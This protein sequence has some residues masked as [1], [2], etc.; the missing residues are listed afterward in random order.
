MMEGMKKWHEM[1][2]VSGWDSVRSTERDQPL[3][4]DLWP[5]WMPQKFSG[6]W[7]TALSTT[8]CLTTGMLSTGNA[9]AYL[10]VERQH[11]QGPRSSAYRYDGHVIGKVMDGRMF[12]L[13]PFKD[14]ECG[15]HHPARPIMLPSHPSWRSTSAE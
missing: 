6:A 1:V 2:S 8:L 5:S 12:Q 9:W 13:G 10:L 15:H 11:P 3:P 4:R 14:V 7:R